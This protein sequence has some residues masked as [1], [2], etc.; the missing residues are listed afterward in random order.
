[1]EQV[2]FEKPLPLQVLMAYLDA[3]RTLDLTGKVA[4]DGKL[5]WVAPEGEWTLYAVFQGWHGKMVERAGPGGEGDVIDHFS[6][7][8]L[9]DYL[10][11]FDEAFAGR[12]VQSLRAFFND[13]YEVDDAAG[14]A[15]WTPRLFDEFRRRRG[16]DLRDH[17][18]ALFGKDSPEKKARVLCD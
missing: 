10:R 12:D 17:L 15:G 13:S 5:D 8:A 16:Y 3:G 4:A 1:L 7:K 9:D 11:R 14:E 18:P 2:R 6:R